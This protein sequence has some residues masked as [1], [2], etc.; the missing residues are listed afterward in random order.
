MLSLA[1][2]LC[3]W[4]ALHPPLRFTHSHTHIHKPLALLYGCIS[5]CLSSP[6]ALSSAHPVRYAH[7][8]GAPLPRPALL[9][10]LPY[11]YF[12]FPISGHVPFSHLSF[13]F[14]HSVCNL[15]APADPKNTEGGSERGDGD[16]LS[17]NTQHSFKQCCNYYANM[18]QGCVFLQCGRTEQN[19]S[20]NVSVLGL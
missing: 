18:G 11:S 6:S 17:F 20:Y 2:P 4:R 9:L 5:V 13:I 1:P 16:S 14:F 8:P 15:W 10:L 12:T 3:R 7:K 19:Q